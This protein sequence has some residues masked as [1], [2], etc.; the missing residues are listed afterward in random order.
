[1]KVTDQK[2]RETNTR[3]EMKPRD[4]DVGRSACELLEGLGTRELEL[5]IAEP[6]G[7]TASP[8]PPPLPLLVGEI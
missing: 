8:P 5:G 7:Q 1:M 4:K 2:P 6:L 3:K